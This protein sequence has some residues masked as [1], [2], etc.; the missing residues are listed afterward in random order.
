[1][2]AAAKQVDLSAKIEVNALDYSSREDR[3][4]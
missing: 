1:M 2:T 4:F 3:W